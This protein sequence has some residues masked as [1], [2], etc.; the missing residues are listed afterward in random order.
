MT[1]LE[2]LQFYVSTGYSW[3]KKD[4]SVDHFAEIKKNYSRNPNSMFELDNDSMDQY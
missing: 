2:Y 4:N 1:K 3:R